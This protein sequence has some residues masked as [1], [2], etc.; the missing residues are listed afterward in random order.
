MNKQKVQQILQI[1]ASAQEIHNSA[2]QEAKKI[3]FDA[4]TEVDDLREQMHL[5]VKHETEKILD[6]ALATER[7]SR[8]LNQSRRDG[9]KKEDQ[10]KK[11]FDNAVSFVLDQ[12][13]K[14]G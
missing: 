8:I 7:R 2:Q 9:E 4:Q 10:A 11:N 13:A 14:Q 5:D 12:I 6:Q 1:E 3:V